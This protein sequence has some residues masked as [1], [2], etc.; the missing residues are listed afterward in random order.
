[1]Q[2]IL[3]QIP[4]KLFSPQLQNEQ[5]LHEVTSASAFRASSG[6]NRSRAMAAVVNFIPS[7]KSATFDKTSFYANSNNVTLRDVAMFKTTALIRK[8]LNL[9]ESSVSI[10]SGCGVLFPDTKNSSS[11]S[12]CDRDASSWDRDPVSST[13]GEL[14]FDKVW[15][16]TDEIALNSVSPSLPAFG[17][18]LII[19]F[20]F[21]LKQKFSCKS[22]V[23]FET[24]HN[25][26]NVERAVFIKQAI[27]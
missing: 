18:R 13:V 12:N 9:H 24:S 2:Y 4:N 16:S 20:C 15:L 3:Q 22:I 27:H 11:S 17:E 21:N 14:A 10:I 1:M 23:T 7:P 19:S 5:R 6:A 26:L 8:S 25:M